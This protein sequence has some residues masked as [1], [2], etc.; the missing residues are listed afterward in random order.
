[1]CRRLSLLPL[2][3]LLLNPERDQN[4][5]L[6]A[7]SQWMGALDENVTLRYVGR[8]ATAADLQPTF[9]ESARMIAFFEQRAG[10]SYPGDTYAQALVARTVGQ[11]MAGLSIFSEEYGR[12]VIADP[13]VTGLIAH[14][15]A[16]Q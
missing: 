12:A 9:D 2:A 3:G 14:E 1:M 7:T 6:C 4:Y 5:T 10:V 15:L 8:H 11:E 13:S 16:H